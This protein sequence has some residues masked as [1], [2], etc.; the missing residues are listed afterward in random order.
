VCVYIYIYI[1]IL[2]IINIV[3]S[4]SLIIFYK[5]EEMYYILSK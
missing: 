3:F 2:K 5:F 1:Y 4:E